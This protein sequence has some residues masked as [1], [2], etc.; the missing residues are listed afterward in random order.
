MVPLRTPGKVRD[1]VI[2]GLGVVS[3]I[4][5][6]RA[7]VWD[8]L[9][10]G[11]SGVRPISLYPPGALPVPFGGEVRDF[12]PKQYVRPRKSLKVM[13]RD[14]QLAMCAAELAIEDGRGT[15]SVVL[16]S[17]SKRARRD[18]DLAWRALGLERTHS[19][20]CFIAFM[21]ASICLFSVSRRASFC[22]SQ[23]E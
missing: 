12:D 13:S 17:S 20:S 23:D 5:I 14:I 4:G 8:S 22:S 10:A 11:R 16:D 7:A 18:F 2:T 6:G 15:E 21:W 3:P 19:S 9:M 1:I